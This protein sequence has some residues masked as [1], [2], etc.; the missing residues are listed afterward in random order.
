MNADL[1]QSERVKNEEFGIPNGAEIVDVSASATVDKAEAGE[2]GYTIHGLCKY[3]M[4]L[5]SDGE[6][7]SGEVRL[8]FRYDIEGKD[9]IGEINAFD[10]LA[11]VY[12][13]RVRCDGE[14]LNVD[15]EISLGCSMWGSRS[16]DMLESIELSAP[17]ERRTGAI[18]VYY[19]QADDT[20]WSIA[21]KYSVPQSDISGDPQSDPFVMIEL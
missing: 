8:P 12:N 13:V 5:K 14:S 17:T 4:I 11:N 3:S 15:S 16:V 21:K 9:G 6:Y 18:I 19:P 20:V 2:N 10:V 1:S 7:M